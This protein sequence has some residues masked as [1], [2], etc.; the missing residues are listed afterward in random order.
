MVVGQEKKREVVERVRGEEEGCCGGHRNGEGEG[1]GKKRG[2]KKKNGGG[3]RGS[4]ST[5]IEE[6][7]WT[8]SL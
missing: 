4:G 2:K 6:G 8:C 7:R 5:V 1:K 3:G